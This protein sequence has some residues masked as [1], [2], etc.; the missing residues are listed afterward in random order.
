GAYGRSAFDTAGGVVTLL[1]LGRPVRD[2]DAV[3]RLLKATQRPDG[4]FAPADG[5]SHLPTTYRVV[6]AL[7]MLNEQPDLER[8]RALSARCRNPDGGYGPAPGQP[9]GVN[10][11]YYAAIVSHWAGE[12][13][14][15]H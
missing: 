13:E 6:R 8:L 7:R 11:T 4:G 10:P 2:R 5:A 14:G 3:T 1:R 15:P 12:L 9:S